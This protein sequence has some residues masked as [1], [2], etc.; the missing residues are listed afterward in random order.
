MRSSPR[1]GWREGLGSESG[2]GLGLGL[3][4]GLGLGL[5]LGLVVGLDQH[6]WRRLAAH[7]PTPLR[8]RGRRVVRR[9]G[10]HRGR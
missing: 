4:S 6:A 10:A 9:R 1:R 3:G 5:G 2:L 7:L 8:R